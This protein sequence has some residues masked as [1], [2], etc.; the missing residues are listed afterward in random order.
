MCLHNALGQTQ[1]KAATF[2]LMNQAVVYPVKFVKHSALLRFGNS[3]SFVGYFDSDMIL[4]SVHSHSDFLDLRRVL[5][6][7]V[8][9]VRYGLRNRL[10]VHQRW[11]QS[12]LDFKIDRKAL[13]SDLIL[14]QPD[15]F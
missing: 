6:R 3:N 10:T 1:T 5:Q 13:G 4:G 12:L 7:I 8:D 2:G 9:Q 11:W 15:G 14:V